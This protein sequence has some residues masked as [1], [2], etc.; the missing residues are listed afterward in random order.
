MTYF[1]V[2]VTINKDTYIHNET[3]VVFEKNNKLYIKRK[4]IVYKHDYSEKS[5]RFHSVKLN[6]RDENLHNMANNLLPLI[7]VLPSSYLCIW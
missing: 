2:Q 3:F 5:L 7:K 4:L 6:V 1:V